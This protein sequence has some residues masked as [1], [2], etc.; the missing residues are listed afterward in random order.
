[1]KNMITGNFK[2]KTIDTFLWNGKPCWVGTQIVKVLDYEK[3]SK[4]LTR[5]IQAESFELGYEYELVSG[6][7]L[8]DIKQKISKEL[9]EEIKFSGKIILLYE[10]GLYGFLQYTDKPIGVSFRTWIRREVLPTFKEIKTKEKNEEIYDDSEDMV[11]RNQFVV[12]RN[13]VDIE[14]RELL[15]LALKNALMLNDLMGNTPIDD[16]EKLLLLLSLYGEAGINLDVDFLKSRSN[17]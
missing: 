12:P 10:T 11:S 13:N 2:G 8:K 7:E 5:C 1:M 6:E 14:D 16:D 3:V 9:A 17:F 4:P 15:K